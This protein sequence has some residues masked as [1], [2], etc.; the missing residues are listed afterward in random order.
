M[1][2]NDESKEKEKSEKFRRKACKS[3]YLQSIIF[4]GENNFVIVTNGWDLAK[5]SFHGKVIVETLQY[6]IY[7]YICCNFSITVTK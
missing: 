4:S 2:P 3:T 7:A 5:A 1:L 6:D